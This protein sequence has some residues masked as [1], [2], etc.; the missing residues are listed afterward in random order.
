MAFNKAWYGPSRDGTSPNPLLDN[1][2]QAVLA[3][4]HLWWGFLRGSLLSLD[5]AQANELAVTT[6]ALNLRD[7][8]I[9]LP[10]LKNAKANGA[11][12][13]RNLSYADLARAFEGGIKNER[14]LGPWNADVTDLAAFKAHG[15]KLIMYHGLADEAIPYQGS[16][17]YYDR[18]VETMGGLTKVQEFFR[19]YIIPG[20]SHHVANAWTFLPKGIAGVSPPPDPP[21]P[22]YQEL[23]G[24]LTNWVERGVPPGAIQM[25]NQSK[26]LSRPACLY[27]QRIVYQG[28]DVGLSTSFSCH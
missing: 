9:G 12:G 23:F 11:D 21:L 5:Q 10:T 17:D 22:T 13:W 3:P 14:E 24:A 19:F 7:P 2:N 16:R 28:G 4:D 18:V 15:G 26:T 1:G 27:P 8:A 20:Q 6:V 25:T